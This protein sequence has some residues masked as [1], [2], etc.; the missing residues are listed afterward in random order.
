MDSNHRRHSQQIYSLPHLATL[1]TTLALKKRLQRY[2]FYFIPPNLL[3]LISIYF[4]I[5]LLWQVLF[6]VCMGVAWVVF[7]KSCRPAIFFRKYLGVPN[8]FRTFAMALFLLASPKR[9]IGF[10]Q[11][12]CLLHPRGIRE[13][14]QNF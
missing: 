9:H 12:P 2:Y 7:Y 13:S 8:L 10:I 5:F 1:V 11:E 14:R 6:L 4:F 3:V